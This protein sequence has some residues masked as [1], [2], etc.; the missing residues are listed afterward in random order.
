MK[1]C[2]WGHAHR[3]GRQRT[4]WRKEWGKDEWLRGVSPNYCDV[5]Q[6]PPGCPSPWKDLTQPPPPIKKK[7]SVSLIS[8]FCSFEGDRICR[9]AWKMITC[10]CM[11]V[12]AC[13]CVSAQKL[14][15]SWTRRSSFNALAPPP[16]LCA[17]IPNNVYEITILLVAMIII[18]MVIKQNYLI[19]I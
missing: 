6:R 13:L 17:F 19:T 9:C 3:P 15:R 2:W 1:P 10:V 4:T 14:N 12:G 18:E 7:D 16:G 8:A 11:H 5:R